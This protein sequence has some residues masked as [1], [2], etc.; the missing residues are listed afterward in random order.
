MISKLDEAPVTGDA[1]LLER[2][3]GN[4]LDNA[5][6]YNIDGGTVLR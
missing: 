2:L 4:L 3:I 6:R 1:V 5:E